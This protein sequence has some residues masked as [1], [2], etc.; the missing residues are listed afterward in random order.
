MIT[1][2]VNEYNSST[3]LASS[4]DYATKDLDILFE[5][6]AYRYFEVP[7]EVYTQFANADSQGSALNSLIKNGNYRCEKL[8]QP[9]EDID[10]TTTDEDAATE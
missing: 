10:T 6:G 1:R 8:S 5:N 4:Y 3:V 2:Q 7:V 9:S